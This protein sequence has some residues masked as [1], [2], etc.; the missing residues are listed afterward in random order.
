MR[1]HVQSNFEQ[2]HFS[3]LAEQLRGSGDAL[4]FEENLSTENIR[5]LADA[6][7]ETCGGKAMVFSGNDAAGYQYAIA[8]KEGD[9]RADVKAMNEALNG[10]GGGRDANFVQGSVKAVRSEK[11]RYIYR[12]ETPWRCGKAAVLNFFDIVYKRTVRRK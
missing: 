11:L 9:V 7:K 12:D 8:V 4:V 6:I 5:R 1:W 10:R 2:E 3:N